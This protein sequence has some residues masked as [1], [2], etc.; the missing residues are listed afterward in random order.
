[1]YVSDNLTGAMIQEFRYAVT[2][3]VEHAS[4]G[5]D[6]A[7]LAAG[8]ASAIAQILTAVGVSDADYWGDDLPG[9]VT[10]ACTEAG[11]DPAAMLA[12]LSGRSSKAPAP[13]VTVTRVEPA[14]PAVSPA[15]VD[16]FDVDA[17]LMSVLNGDAQ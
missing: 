14:P 11:A 5:C 10:T 15:D 4:H 7:P 9:Q 12:M 2:V 3:L 16:A 13:D 1:M 17:F 8:R 6:L